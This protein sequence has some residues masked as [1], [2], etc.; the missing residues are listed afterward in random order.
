V[1]GPPFDLVIGDVYTFLPFGNSV[2]TRNV[3][4][5]QLWAALENGVSQLS[6]TTCNGADGRFPQIS[7]FRFSFSCSA[8]AGNRV[9]AVA[10]DD[11]TP[12]AADSTSYSLATNDFVNAGGDSYTVFKDGQ[13][14]TREVMADVLLEYIKARTPISPTLDG[15]ITKLP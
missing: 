10:L 8:P 3:S 15:R 12:I 4:G 6:P 1:I 7:G 13:G 11:G 5:A 2:V 9:V 14:V